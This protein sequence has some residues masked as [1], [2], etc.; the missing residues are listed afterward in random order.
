MKK[1]QPRILFW[2]IETSQMT[3]KK[4]GLVESKHQP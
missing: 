2:D 3:T 4:L 1:K